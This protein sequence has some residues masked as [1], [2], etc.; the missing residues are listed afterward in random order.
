MYD[1]I[2]VGDKVKAV[3]KCR[4]CKEKYETKPFTHAAYL[5]WR[6]GLKPIQNTLLGTELEAHDRE[7]L[8][9]GISPIGWSHLE[10]S[11]NE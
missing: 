10:G 5:D 9:S 11:F 7:F 4:Q 8:I 1:L 3:G 2:I 6:R